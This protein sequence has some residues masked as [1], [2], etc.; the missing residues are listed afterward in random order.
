[1]KYSY[2]LLRMLAVAALFTASLQSQSVI[3]NETHSRGVAGDL[4][5]IEVYNTTGSAVD[6]SG[7][8]IYDNGGQAGT[9]SKKQF[10]AGTILP[11][12]GFFA[13]VVDTATFVGDTSGFGISSGGE[14]VWLENPA[15]AVIDTCSIPALGTDTSYA[16]IP[17]G[18]K[19]WR[20]TFPRTKG[21]TNVAIKMN[22]T[23]SRGAAGNLDWI[24]VHNNSA[25]SI[26]ISGYKIYDNGGQAGTKSKKLFPAGTIVPA[27]GFAVIIVDTATFVG[28]TSGFGIGSG[29]ETV[30]L[31]NAAGVLID[32]VAIP[33]L[34]IDTSYAR[35]P[36]GSNLMM[37]RTPVTKGFSN[38]TVVT[39]TNGRTVAREY[40]LEQNYPNPFNPSTTIRFRMASAGA[41]KLAVYDLL[42]KQVALLINGN[43]AAGEQTVQFRAPHLSS[44]VY[45]YQLTAGTYS[46]MKKM[47]LMK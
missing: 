7:Y 15:G 1:M 28:D 10:P 3:I 42:G 23:Y 12:K 36:D 5:W 27:N 32:T 22:E 2:A 35:V 21:R 43:I 13:I 37:K 29:G 20:K 31:E 44:G 11:P 34:G 39:V 24:E 46:E 30:W 8:K 9:K 41:V 33:A 14:T 17:D 25:A 4:D 6:I 38:G 18:G 19:V 16:R 45:F 40:S 47:V 26:D